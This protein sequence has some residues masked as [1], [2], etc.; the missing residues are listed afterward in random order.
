MFGLILRVWNCDGV[1]GQWVQSASGLFDCCRIG[2]LIGRPVI[3]QESVHLIFDVTQLSINC[4]RDAIRGQFSNCAEPVYNPGLLSGR[5]R[6]ILLIGKWTIRIPQM[7][8]N[9]KPCATK[10]SDY[11]CP[12]HLHRNRTWSGINVRI[13]DVSCAEIVPSAGV[14]DQPGGIPG[15]KQ[16]GYSNRIILAPTFIE[17]DPHHDGRMVA[18]GVDHRFHFLLDLSCLIG[19]ARIVGRPW[20]FK[21]VLRRR[22]ILPDQKTELVRPV[23]PPLGFNFYMFSHHVAAD[24]LL[25]VKIGSQSCIGGSE[26]DSVW[27]KPLIQRT[28]Q[29]EWLIVKKDS[30]ISVGIFSDFH[31]AHAEVACHRIGIVRNP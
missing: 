25:V 6:K 2:F 18:M 24:Q 11:T 16:I 31:L 28:K 14:V 8:R 1:I 29:K 3:G 19:W 27:P 12:I 30:L 4:G 17:S 10:F 22:K 26:I 23:V 5:I 15:L 13:K 7:A 20:P 21:D 9:G